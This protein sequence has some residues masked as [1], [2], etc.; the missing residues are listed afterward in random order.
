LFAKSTKRTEV[1]DTHV[2]KRFPYTAPT[3][4][5]YHSWNVETVHEYRE[6]IENLLVSKIQTPEEWDVEII[7]FARGLLSSKGFQFHAENIF[8][9]FST[10]WQI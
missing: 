1:L 8:F 5:Q 10:F 2:R 3:W 4:W 9:G 6:G 7:S